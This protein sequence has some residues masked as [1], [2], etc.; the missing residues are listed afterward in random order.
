MAKG[1]Y[2]PHSP[3][4][5]AMKYADAIKYRTIFSADAV[6]LRKASDKEIAYMQGYLDARKDIS[7]AWKVKYGMKPNIRPFKKKK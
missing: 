7:N 1:K 4:F 5:K 3:S 6:P 2:I